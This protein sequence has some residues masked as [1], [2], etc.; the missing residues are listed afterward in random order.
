MC[1][2][3][4]WVN[5]PLFGGAGWAPGG[6]TQAGWEAVPEAVQPVS[7]YTRLLARPMHAGGTVRMCAGVESGRKNPTCLAQL[8][9]AV[10]FTKL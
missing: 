10:L 8:L 5:V 9:A 1:V 2:W 6:A 3:Y 7:V 4:G